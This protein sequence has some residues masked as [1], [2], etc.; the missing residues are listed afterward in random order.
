ML[1]SLAGDVQE[2]HA[3]KLWIGV[4]AAVVDQARAL[5]AC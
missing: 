1:H 5:A 2:E 3:F 4:G